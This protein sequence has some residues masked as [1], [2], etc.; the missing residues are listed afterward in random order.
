M[1][2]KLRKLCS[3]TF[4]LHF[5]KILQSFYFYF[6]FTEGH[7]TMTCLIYLLI[8]FYNI[9]LALWGCSSLLISY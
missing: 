7:L 8:L 4:F 2:V 9:N 6:Y 1:S 3:S 5:G